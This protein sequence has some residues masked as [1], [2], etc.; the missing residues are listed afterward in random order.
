MP[1]D[2]WC[3][4]GSLVFHRTITRFRPPMSYLKWFMWNALSAALQTFG[5]WCTW[6]VLEDEADGTSTGSAK[7]KLSGGRHF[8]KQRSIS[9][10]CHRLKSLP[11]ALKPVNGVCSMLIA[12]LLTAV[13]NMLLKRLVMDKD[14]AERHFMLLSLL[15]CVNSVIWTIWLTLTL[16]NTSPKASFMNCKVVW[17]DLST[18]SLSKQPLNKLWRKINH[19]LWLCTS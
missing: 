16:L 4:K 9:F 13:F 6:D 1:Q 8:Q 7:R 3:I 14:K 11:W 19:F 18:F 17:L 10:R 5:Q 15:S 2:F 12:A